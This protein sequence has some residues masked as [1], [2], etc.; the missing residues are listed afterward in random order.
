VGDPD[1]GGIQYVTDANLA[2]RQRLWHISR[3]EPD[4]SLYSWVIGLARLQGGEAILDVGC[5]NGPYLELV[6]AV[7]LDCSS[8]M[9]AA[10]RLRT[11]GPLVAG[12]AGALP[13]GAG[14]FDVVLA[15]HMLYHVEDRA[16][17]AHEFRRVLAPS[18]VCI[19][20][21]NGA[22]TQRELV[23]LLEDVVGGGWRWRRPS[24]V[25][26]SLDNGAEQLGVAFEQ[27]DLLRCP[28]GVVQV[29]DAD[30]L[31]DYLRSVGDVYGGEIAQA[32]EDVVAHCRQRV[33]ATIAQQGAFAITASVG[34]FICS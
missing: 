33:A 31:A 3:R 18:G 29:T 24:E 10:A 7:G 9:L 14:V 19:V 8:G 1:W 30:A 17:A 32:W 5:G 20:V 34:A 13:F 6:E 28:P 16:A 26:F 15:P 22:D 23:D 21:T 2:A 27:V 12:D 4:F 11:T 25:A